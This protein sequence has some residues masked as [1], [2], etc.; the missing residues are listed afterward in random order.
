ML[1]SEVISLHLQLPSRK[2]TPNTAENKTNIHNMGNFSLFYFP[3]FPQFLNLGT[4]TV[5]LDKVEVQHCNI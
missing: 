4:F 2:I 5:I 1:K 3:S